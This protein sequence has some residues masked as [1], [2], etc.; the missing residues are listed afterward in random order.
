VPRHG[1][2]YGALRHLTADDPEVRRLRAA[3][4]RQINVNFT[5]GLDAADDEPGLIVDEL[6]GD[7]CGESTSGGLRPYALHLE[8]ERT[9][10]GQLLVEWHHSTNL[11]RTETV[12]RIAARFRQ[13]V[14]SLTEHLN[15]N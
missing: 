2:G 7:L 1:V 11:H 10:E 14:E 9:G 5:G 8:I 13:A 15:R 12:R 3:P 6:P 4:D